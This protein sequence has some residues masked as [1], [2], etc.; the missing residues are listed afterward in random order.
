MPFLTAGLHYGIGV[1]EGIRCYDTA[2]G[3]AVFRLA[4]HVRRLFASAR[5]LGWRDLPYDEERL[6]TAIHETVTANQLRA[7]YI[8]PLIYLAEGGMD[9]SLDTG[10]A[11]VGI[12][13]WA[14]KDYHGETTSDAGIRINVSSYTRH[15]PNIMP[16]RAKVS[17]NYV[18]SFLARTESARLG[19]DDA[20]LLD[21]EGYVAECTGENLFVVSGGRIVTPPVAGI[22]EGIT[23]DTVLTLARDAGLEVTEERLVRDRLYDA[24]EVFLSGTAAE[25]VAVR[26][27]DFRPVGSGAVGPITRTIQHAFHQMVRGEHPRSAEWLEPVRALSQAGQHQT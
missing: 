1:F 12:A 15:H 19:F 25:I 4:D 5:T 2:A 22:L 6:T 21:P 9:L 27:V 17:G 3:P 7:C 23:R 16:T 18:N 24:D 8:R 14:W 26:E 13:A 10:R 20:V 11:H